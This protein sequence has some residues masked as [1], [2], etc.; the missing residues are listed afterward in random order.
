L[1]L[2]ISKGF[3]DILGGKIWVNSEPKKGANF[4]FN[5]PY[6]PEKTL[7]QS[8]NIGIAINKSIIVLVAEDEI[9]NFLLLQEYLE[10]MDI[11]VLHAENGQQAVDICKANSN[12][13]LV[14]MDIKMPVMDGFEA[15]VLI[16]K[17]QPDLPIIAQS[18]YALEYERQKYGTTFNEYLNKP[19]EHAEL[20]QKIRNFIL[21]D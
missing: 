12:I 14:L 19:I 3:I 21:M 17:M 18:A 13:S 20:V 8:K 4:Y 6:L 9:N 2:S 7:S 1:G 10:R 5:I 15:A 16:K 11:N